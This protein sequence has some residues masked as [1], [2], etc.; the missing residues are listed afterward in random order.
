MGAG[1][2]RMDLIQ[3]AGKYPPL[4]GESD[5]L[6][7]EGEHKPKSPRVNYYLWHQQPK[8]I[9]TRVFLI[10][11]PTLAIPFDHKQTDIG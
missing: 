5:I 9:F 10:S 7:V 6:G 1:V 3:V 4:P 8:L 2:N 11:S